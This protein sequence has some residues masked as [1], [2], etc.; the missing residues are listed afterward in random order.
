M[1]DKKVGAEGDR[2]IKTP[3]ECENCRFIGKD[4]QCL[5]DW[6]CIEEVSE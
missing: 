5:A 3:V 6:P 2:D 4:D 1:E